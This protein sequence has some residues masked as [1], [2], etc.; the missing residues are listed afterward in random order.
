MSKPP[1]PHFCVLSIAVGHRLRVAKLRS[2]SPYFPVERSQRIRMVCFTCCHLCGVHRPE[3]GDLWEWEKMGVFEVRFIGTL[4][5]LEKT[6]RCQE[7]AIRKRGCIIS[8]K[9]KTKQKAPKSNN[10]NQ[11]I[12]IIKQQQSKT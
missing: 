6:G 1:Y 12:A 7:R 8:R 9:A 11:D 3:R 10:S 2:Q 4:C 5:I